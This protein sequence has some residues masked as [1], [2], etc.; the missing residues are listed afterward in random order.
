MPQ[1]MTRRPPFI[2]TLVASLLLLLAPTGA[3]VASGNPAAS[4]ATPPPPPLVD[5]S[6]GLLPGQADSKALERIGGNLESR[7]GRYHDLEDAKL[8]P[9]AQMRASATALSGDYR[10]DGLLSPW[11][12]DSPSTLTY[13]FYSD[14]VF[15]GEYYGTETVSELSEP[16]K[17]NVREIMTWYGALLDIDLVEVQEAP[18]SIGLIRIMGSTAPGYAYSYYPAG[19]NP[20]SVAGDVHLN[21]SFDRLGDT[22]GF[23]HPAGQHGY[24]TLIHE[25]GHTLGLKHPFSGTPVLPTS[26]DNDSNTVMSYAWAGSSPGTPMVYDLLALQYVYGARPA[27]AG[28]DNYAFT[29]RG[30]DQYSLNGQTFLDTPY[31]TKQVLWDS[32]GHN[33]LD[34]SGLP[35]NGSGYRLDLRGSGW[36]TAQSDYISNVNGIYFY[37]GTAL[38]APVA[39]GAVVNSGSS[40]TIYANP[41]ANVIGGYSRNR[42]TGHDIVYEAG[43]EDVLD[44]SGYSTADVVQTRS[45]DDLLLDLGINGSIT[46]KG[47]YLGSAPEISFSAVAPPNTPPVAVALA[48]PADGYAPLAVSF[49]A[50][51]S[52]DA[53]GTIVYYSW[54][55]GDGATASGATSAHTYQDPGTFTAILTVTDS[56]GASAS[57]SVAVS[58]REPPTVRVIRVADLSI[59]AVAE[60][61]KGKVAQVVAAVNDLT[62]SPVSGAVVTGTW[63]GLVSGTS[64]GTTGVDGKTTLTSKSTNRAGSVTFTLTSVSPPAGTVYDAAENLESSAVVT[65]TR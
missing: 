47:Y 34:V 60:S 13:S 44:L 45:G 56:S 3:G 58:V 31:A 16:V 25:I 37:K 10:I 46:L 64:S 1:L 8:P 14:A 39:V 57:S 7:G 53:D 38:A 40:D 24:A 49:D 15:G 22:N 52:A 27:N 36:I 11:R 42:S 55:F 12:W 28:N 61:R 65:I 54:D 4:L 5:P 41:S 19:T 30:A 48:I 62:G 17:R 50:T 21:P 29:L 32:G 51:Q 35:S 2:A 63:S 33:I 43:S 20:F 9:E 26:E 23:Q 6:S 59:S 18:T